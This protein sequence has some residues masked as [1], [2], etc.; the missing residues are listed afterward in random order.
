[1]LHALSQHEGSTLCCK[2]GR[3]P[4]TTRY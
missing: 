3:I 1:V 2:C 4:W